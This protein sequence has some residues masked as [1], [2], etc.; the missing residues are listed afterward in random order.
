MADDF[1]Y[2]GGLGRV[3]DDFQ[4]HGGLGVWQMIFN[5][6]GG[7]NVYRIL[8]ILIPKNIIP[9]GM[10]ITAKSLALAIISPFYFLHLYYAPHIA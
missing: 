3:A 5:I 6:H 8:K 2:H 10:G 4:Y 7:G 1:Q 9:Q